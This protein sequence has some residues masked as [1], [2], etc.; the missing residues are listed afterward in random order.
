MLRRSHLS[1]LSPGGEWSSKEPP[2]RP[3]KTRQGQRGLHSRILPAALS[4]SQRRYK[5]VVQIRKH[6]THKALR[7]LPSSSYK[8]FQ[9]SRFE[10]RRLQRVNQLLCF[11]TWQRCSRDFENRKPEERENHKKCQDGELEFARRQ[12]SLTSS[13]SS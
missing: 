6:H 7:F 9:H 13:F 5:E 11:L 10:R 8:K 12:R 4:D 3:A 2:S 1:R